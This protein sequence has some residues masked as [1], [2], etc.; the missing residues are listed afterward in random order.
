MQALYKDYSGRG[1]TLVFLNAN[2]NEPAAE[3]AQHAKKNGFSFPVYKDV[4]NV[5]ADRLQ[6]ETTP[7]VFL[8]GKD[9]AVI[10]RGAID[11]ARNKDKITKTHLREALDAALAGKPLPVAETKAFGCSIKRANKTS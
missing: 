8:I 11:D 3:V 1:V 5:E 7:H 2:S 6:A 9:S 4:N 10:Y